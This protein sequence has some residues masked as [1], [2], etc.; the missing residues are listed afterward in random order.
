M[1]ETNEDD[2]KESKPLEKVQMK[3]LIIAFFILGVGCFDAFVVFL[4]ERFGGKKVQEAQQGI[5]I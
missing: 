3:H 1:F 2:K 5:E 4:L